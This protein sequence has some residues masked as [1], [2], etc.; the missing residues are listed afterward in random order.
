MYKIFVGNV[1]FT[2][3]EEQIKQVFDPHIV[4]EDIVIARDESG[5]SKGYGFVLTRDQ[6]KARAA[7]RQIG[8]P[9][10]G[11]RRLYFKEAHGKK[12]ASNG[13]PQRDRPLRGRRPFR[14]RTPRPRPQIGYSSASAA[15]RTS[16]APAPAPQ[17]PPG[18]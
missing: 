6:D 3:T 8:K 16:V 15:P 4:V 10:V 17:S 12:V 1:S 14:P 2:A 7:L 18:A 5:K 13:G 11:G 9:L